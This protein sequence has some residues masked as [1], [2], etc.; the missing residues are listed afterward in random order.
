MN[1][2][3]LTAIFT[4]AVCAF[5]LFAGIEISTDRK[6][7]MYRCGETAA[8]TVKVTGTN[9]L[10]KAGAVTVV[11]DNFG[12]GV[13]ASNDFAL[14]AS[15]P[16]VIRGK[17]DDPGFLRLTVRDGTKSVVWGVGY[18]PERIRAVTQVPDDFDAFWADAKKMLAAEIPL[19]A[20]MTKVPER[21]T[22]KFDFYR[23]SF[24][25][26]GR[27]VH[28][29]MSI[30]TDANRAPFPVELQVAAAGFGNWTNDMS[31]EADRIKV[32]FGVYPFE[33]HW[34]WKK[35]GLEAKYKEQDKVLDAKY[36]CGRYC[37]AGSGVSREAYFYYPVILGIDRAVDWLA[38]RPDVDPKRIRYQGTSQG[39]GMGL[40]LT[41]L[42]K[43]I[44]RAA[45]FVP[46]MTDTLAGQ[47][48]RQ[49]GWPQPVESQS[50]PEA[51][52]MTAKV[53]PYFDGAVFATRITCPVRFAVGLA[54]NTCPPHCTWAAYN[55]IA[56]E[57][58]DIVYGIGMGHGC[59]GDFYKKH[60]D[61]L[62]AK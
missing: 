8:F 50:T 12:P 57:D 39:G 55:A 24:A 27:R 18:E 60:G 58:K 33:P 34:Q 28:G 26:F 54:D 47:A 10:A 14:A 49:S 5:P 53:M 11:L 29:Y 3:K 21:C 2:R 35:L 52:A 59:R 13:I 4:F 15:N 56:S 25:T 31:G 51:K 16:I 36:H 41:A 19:D 17:R 46:A 42:N 45:F 30:P 23:I 7:A 38:A 37:T 32:F 22:V 62:N 61:W 43:H 20:Q 9:G 1:I 48:G 40:A 44:S 6:N